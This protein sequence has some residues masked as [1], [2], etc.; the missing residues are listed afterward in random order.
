MFLSSS[1]IYLAFEKCLSLGAG[2]GPKQGAPMAQEKKWPVDAVSGNIHHRGRVENT[3]SSLWTNPWIP[4]MD[5]P[6]DSIHGPQ[7]FLKFNVG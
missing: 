5:H 1:D 4:S 2:H 3:D 7:H 6:M